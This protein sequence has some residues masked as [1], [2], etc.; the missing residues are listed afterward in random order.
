MSNFNPQDYEVEIVENSSVVVEESDAVDF[1]NHA[2]TLQAT[3][4]IVVEDDGQQDTI[5]EESDLNSPELISIADWSNTNDFTNYIV[6][7]A[8]DI[9]QTFDGSKNSYKR[10]F[11]YL[12]KLSN[13]IAQGVEQDS[14]F[15]NLNQ[16]QLSTLDAIEEG[17][18]LSLRDLAACSQGKISKTATKS[19]NFVYYVNPFIFGLARIIVNGKVSQGKNIET[20]FGT[21]NKK[22]KLNERECLELHF[23]LNDMG[24]PIRSSFVEGVDMSE[25]YQA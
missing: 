18:E 3:A 17:I 4:N 8:R 10:A 24:Y 5:V 25:I 2:N 6:T 9:P 7:S 1:S 14:E 19:S 23:I 12:E 22:Y 11:A 15:S 20:L 21:L 13:E 16:E